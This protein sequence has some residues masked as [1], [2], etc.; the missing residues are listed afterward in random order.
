MNA[1]KHGAGQLQTGVG[2]ILQAGDDAEALGIALVALEIGPLRWREGMAF[3]QP[4]IAE[5]FADGILAGMTERRIADIVRQAGSGNDCPE[6]ARLDVAQTMAGD[7]LAADD[8]AQRAA[9]A[10]GLE[11]VR[12]AGADIVAFRQRKDLRLVLH[13]PEGGGEDDAVVILLERRALRRARRLAGAQA[14]GRQQ[15]FPD[16]SFA[17]VFQVR[18]CDGLRVYSASITART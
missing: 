4:G 6:I 16:F 1:A 15:L 3:E 10:T 13:A 7:D 5:P 12:Q 18:R 17:H 8:G 11:T 9:D 14:L 2:R